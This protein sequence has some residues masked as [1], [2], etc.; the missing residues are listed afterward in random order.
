MKKIIIISLTLTFFASF[1]TGQEKGVPFTQADRELLIRYDERFE[2]MDA[3]I[4]ALETKMD[5]RFESQQRQIDN[6][7]RTFYWGFGTVI[8][9]LISLFAYIVWDRRTAILPVKEKAL[10][11]ETKTNLIEKALKDYSKT[12]PELAEIMRTRGLL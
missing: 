5:V 6:L 8:A 4:Q 7:A 9:L 11:N 2:T 1:A 3:K 12:K 10:D